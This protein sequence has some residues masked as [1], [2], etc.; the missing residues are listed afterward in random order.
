MVNCILVHFD[1]TIAVLKTSLYQFEQKLVVRV[2]V[3]IK[4]NSFA[5]LIMHQIDA[6]STNDLKINQNCKSKIQNKNENQATK[7]FLGRKYFFY[8]VCNVNK[9]ANFFFGCLINF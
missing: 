4:I 7:K 3:H 9:K 1:D 5:S 2:P 6:K 8:S